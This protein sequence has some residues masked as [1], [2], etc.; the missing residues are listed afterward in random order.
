MKFDVMLL[1]QRGECSELFYHSAKPDQIQYHDGTLLLQSDTSISFDGY[2]NLFPQ[3]I[4]RNY[5][6]CTSPMLHVRLKGKGIVFL[7]ACDAEGHVL[8]EGFSHI[9][10]DGACDKQL[11][12]PDL[13]AHAAAVY[14]QFTAETDCVL[15]H[16]YLTFAESA[17]RDVRLAVGI[18]T[19][20]REEFVKRNSAALISFFAERT[21]HI[22]HLF[23]SDNG[24]TLD[25]VLPVSSYLTAVKNP[26]TGGSG[27]FARVMLE[28]LRSETAFTHILLMDDDVLFRPEILD[29]L[30]FFLSHCREEYAHVTVGGAMCLLDTPWMQFEAGAKFQNGG[31]LQGLMQNLDLRNAETCIRNA[32]APQ[33]A[34]YNSWWCCC[35]S[36]ER[37]RTAGLPM[38]FFFKMDD[39]EYALRLGEKVVCL[40]GMCV[41]HEDF[42]KKYNPALEYYIIRNTLITAALHDRLGGRRTMLRN[43][44]SAVLRNVLLQR[45][46]TAELILRAYGDFFKGP[47]FLKDTDAAALH[48][49]ILQC[50]PKCEPMPPEMQPDH[51]QK[52]PKLLRIMTLG[53]ILLPCNRES[54]VVD[55]FYAGTADAFRV[56]EIVHL[57]PMTGMAYRTRLKRTAAMK[58][59]CRTAAAAVKLLLKSH[60]LRKAFCTEAASFA[61]PA[62]WEKV[63]RLG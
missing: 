23:I 27:G 51:A 6:V 37:I 7:T 22:Q 54:A 38:P 46:E 10:A 63:D 15:Q 19:Y 55:A 36:M 21:D 16:G 62:F 14:W 34:D 28:A 13:P 30:W 5:T 56:R 50:A 57:Y 47:A 39:V 12:L 49:A 20:R 41:A 2:Y 60:S 4:Y 17:Q 35:M 52:V 29:R 9:T 61:D 24:G 25:G 3:M 43:L 8:A 45:Y 33:E 42:V 1:P 40:P 32:A 26:N 58:L 59:F 11:Q 31:Y 48:G 53:G 18:C 44:M